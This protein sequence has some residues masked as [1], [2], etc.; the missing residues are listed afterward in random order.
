MKRIIAAL[1][2]VCFL[3]MYV[4][5]IAPVAEAA[6]PYYITIDLTNQIVTVY[7]NGNTSNAGI[8]RQMICSSGKSGTATPT[9]T[10]TLPKKTYSS[11]RTEWYY[12]KKYNCYAKYATRIVGGILFHSVLYSAS[13]VGPTSSSVKALGSPASHGCIRLRVDDAK[14]IAQNCLSGTRCKIYYSGKKNSSL[15]SKLLKK[16]FSRSY[17]TYDS[18]L[19]GKVESPIPLSKGSKG[20]LVKQLQ[21]RLVA[22]GFLNDK[23]DGNFGTKTYNAV[24]YFQTASGLKKTGKVTQEIWDAIF[25]ESAPT[26]MYTTLAKGSSGPAVKVLQQNL[27][28]LKLYDGDVD[29]VFGAGTQTAVKQ[30]QS[31]FGYSADGKATAAIQKAMVAKISDIQATF[32]DQDYALTVETSEISKAKV[33]A[34]SGVKMRKKASTKSKA[35][36]TLKKNT[37]VTVLSKGKKWSK[38]K[39]SKYTGYVM[40]TY[41]SFY[42][43]TKTSLGYEA[44][45]PEVTPAPEVTET[46]VL[47]EVTPAPEATETPVLPEL[48]PTPE[49]TETPVLPEVT[50]VPEVTETP[51]L[52][53]LT[54]KP[55]ATETP[56][57]PELTPKPVATEEIV[58]PELTVSPGTTANGENTSSDKTAVT[59]VPESAAYAELPEMALPAA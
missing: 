42:T 15:R 47:P 55:N 23:A 57:L 38:V 46:P 41:L 32:G 36:R 17:Q 13:K 1:M 26:G 4:P 7:D 9:G 54:P 8:V 31:G 12:F 59:A 29:G 16:S 5:G 3:A 40:N 56:A 25:A 34:K 19:K 58:L 28:T 35:I 2:V 21:S 44:V 33:K 27:K 39:Y 45:L 18:F 49:A 50:P 53:E 6:A 24:C 52:P 20:S 48:T 43:E 11:E 51:V 10:Y 14:W 22:L 37:K 30:F